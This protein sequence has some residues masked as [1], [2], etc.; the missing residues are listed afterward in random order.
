MVD[1]EKKTQVTKKEVKTDEIQ[2][3]TENNHSIDN[4]FEDDTKKDLVKKPE[5]TKEDNEKKYTEN[6]IKNTVNNYVVY[7]QINAAI[8]DAIFAQKRLCKDD[9]CFIKPLLEARNIAKYV[10]VPALY[11]ADANANMVD[12][13]MDKK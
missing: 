7:T 6:D 1:T 2:N 11:I 12:K 8:E 3:A 5:L 9:T 13:N 10:L 4:L